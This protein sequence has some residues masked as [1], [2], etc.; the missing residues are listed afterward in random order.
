[1]SPGKWLHGA[2]R[3]HEAWMF[4]PKVILAVSGLCDSARV[5][6]TYAASPSPIN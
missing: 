3:Q 2:L 4:L 1:M 5:A 6:V